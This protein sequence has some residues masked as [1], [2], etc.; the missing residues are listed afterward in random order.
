MQALIMS[1]TT[2]DLLSGAAQRQ[3]PSRTFA[4]QIVDH[5]SLYKL[6]VNMLLLFLHMRRLGRF[7]AHLSSRAERGFEDWLLHWQF[8]CARTVFYTGAFWRGRVLYVCK[9]VSANVL[10]VCPSSHH[11]AA[12][13]PVPQSSTLHLHRPLADRPTSLLEEVGTRK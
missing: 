9:T 13:A 6:R 8:V 7:T 3:A 11:R 5:V 2:S 1:Q 4:F 10:A 12:W